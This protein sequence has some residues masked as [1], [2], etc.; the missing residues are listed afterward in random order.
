MIT[1][2]LVSENVASNVTLPTLNQLDVG[3]HALLREGFREEVRDVS[4]RVQAT[5]LLGHEQLKHVTP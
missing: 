1:D 3:L 2:L 5:K 4:V